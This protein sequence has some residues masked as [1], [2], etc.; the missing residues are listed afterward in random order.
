MRQINRCLK[1]ALGIGITTSAFAAF[2]QPSHSDRI[3]KPFSCDEVNITTNVDSYIGN[4]SF[5]RWR[6]PSFPPPYS[7]L[8]RCRMVSGRFNRFHN[9]GTLKY[10]STGTLNRHPA[11][12]VAPYRGASDCLPDGLLITLKPGTDP[13]ATLTEIMDKR[14]WGTAGMVELGEDEDGLVFEVNGKIFV[15]I[16]FLLNGE[17]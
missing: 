1:I 9:N 4:Q 17:N 7:P 16:D 5:L 10:I 3:N 11:I 2:P 13:N 12:C 15:D 6:D 14:L 8:E